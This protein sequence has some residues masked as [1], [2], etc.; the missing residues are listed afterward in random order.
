MEKEKTV[1]GRINK[2]ISCKEKKG[3]QKNN[4]RGWVTEND[5]AQEHRFEWVARFDMQTDLEY[6]YLLHKEVEWDAAIE[7]D[8]WISESGI[9]SCQIWYEYEMI[10]KYLYRNHIFEK[11]IN[12][13][14][15]TKTLEEGQVVYISLNKDAPEEIVRISINNECH[16][17]LFYLT[18]A[19]LMGVLLTAVIY[20][21]V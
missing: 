17:T 14:W 20:L 10:V 4:K 2:I 7:K 13:E 11:Q 6:E 3:F 21:L 16:K 1:S 12:W 18:G 9:P 15:R 8:M 19:L 5:F